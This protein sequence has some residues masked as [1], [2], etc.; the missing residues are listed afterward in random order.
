MSGKLV[1]PLEDIDYYETEQVSMTGKRQEHF[2]RQTM[3]GSDHRLDDT[4]VV[5][6]DA[7]LLLDG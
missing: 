7:C 5:D 2:G 6:H 3:H 4:S 1:E